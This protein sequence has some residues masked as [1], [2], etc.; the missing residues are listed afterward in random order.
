VATPL[1][2]LDSQIEIIGLLGIS[3]HATN[4]T[5]EETDIATPF[6]RIQSQTN[7]EFEI[8]QSTTITKKDC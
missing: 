3:V 4:W 8:N 1:L 7:M 2:I 5:Q 6:L